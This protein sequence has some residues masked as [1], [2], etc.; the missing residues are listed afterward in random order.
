MADPKPPQDT[1]ATGGWSGRFS[2]PVSELVKRYTASVDF[3]R[4][5]AAVDIA[6]SLAHARMLKAVGVLSG[7]DLTAIETGME[8][9]RG[10]IARGEFTWS[11]PPPTGGI[12]IWR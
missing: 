3:D 1:A 8:T 6:G 9:V 2:E 10:E 11:R 7:D 4:R 5:L 12:S